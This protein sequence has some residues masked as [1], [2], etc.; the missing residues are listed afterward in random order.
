MRANLDPIPAFLAATSV[1]VISLC[2]YKF[3]QASEER[4]DFNTSMNRLLRKVE[5]IEVPVNEEKED[6]EKD[7]EMGDLERLEA[8]F[9]YKNDKHEKSNGNI[10]SF[11]LDP[12]N[13]YLFRAFFYHYFIDMLERGEDTYQRMM[14]YSVTQ[15]P[16]LSEKTRDLLREKEIISGYQL[17]KMVGVEDFKKAGFSDKEAKDIMDELVSFTFDEPKD[18]ADVIVFLH[19]LYSSLHQEHSFREINIPNYPAMAAAKA[20]LLQRYGSEERLHRLGEIL[21]KDT[22]DCLNAFMPSM[23]AGRHLWHHGLRRFYDIVETSPRDIMNIYGIGK[24]SVRKIDAFL[25]ENG[26]SWEMKDARLIYELYKAGMFFAGD[27]SRKPN[28]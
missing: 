4:Q 19:E 22:L 2:I 13:K 5:S 26:L 9:L 1:A 27:N 20:R 10:E 12:S 15:D 8:M 24:Y 7:D 16:C 28:P 6:E 18:N 14:N 11:L 21:G 3:L 17:F 25:Q 23:S